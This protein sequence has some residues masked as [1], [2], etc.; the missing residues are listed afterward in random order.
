[1]SFGR[2]TP[3]LASLHYPQ[4]PASTARRPTLEVREELRRQREQTVAE[5]WQATQPPA[6]KSKEAP[7]R[8]YISMDGTSVHLTRGWS[9]MRLAAIYETAGVPQ[10]GGQIGPQTARP[11]YLSL[12][13]KVERFGQLVYAEAARRGLEEA[14]EVIILRDGAES[15]WRLAE[16]LCPAAVCIVD[17]WHATEHL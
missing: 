13:V 7:L 10:E 14:G 11:I 12:R 4:V 3:F 5:S 8:L 9:E 16:Q 1:M 17:W 6:R 15:I 2:S